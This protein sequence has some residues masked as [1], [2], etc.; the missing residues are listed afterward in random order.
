MLFLEKAITYL[1]YEYVYID[2]FCLVVVNLSSKWPQM[3]LV[4]STYICQK[5][6][7]NTESNK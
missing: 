6:T 7:F 3:L 5:I 4:T 1:F 2:Q